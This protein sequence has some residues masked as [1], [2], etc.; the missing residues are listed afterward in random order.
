M[1]VLSTSHIL[2]RYT[3]S[4]HC[5]LDDPYYCKMLTLWYRVNGFL[6]KLIFFRVVYMVFVVT[7]SKLFLSRYEF[8]V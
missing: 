2:F 3:K 7:M 4:S 5:I 8:I 1:V 6:G